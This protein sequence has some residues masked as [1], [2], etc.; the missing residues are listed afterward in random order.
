MATNDEEEEE[1]FAV[2]IIEHIHTRMKILAAKTKGKTL[3]GLVEEACI[4]FLNVQ[5]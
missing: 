1:R 3:Q 4:L 2:R 5:K